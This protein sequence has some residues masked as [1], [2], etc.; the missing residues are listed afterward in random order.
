MAGFGPRRRWPFETVQRSQDYEDILYGAINKIIG[1]DWFSRNDDIRFGGVRS[2][3]G[4][5]ENDRRLE[6]MLF[7]DMIRR[8]VFYSSLTSNRV[9][10][11]LTTRNLGTTL[12]SS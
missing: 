10:F 6:E 2:L 9:M 11:F 3:A 12:L 5:P 4:L 1:E 8:H 7:D